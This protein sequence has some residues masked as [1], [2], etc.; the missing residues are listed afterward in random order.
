MAYLVTRGNFITA[1]GTYSKASTSF[2]TNKA[3][4]FKSS[5]GTKYAT[6]TYT[7]SNT[8]RCT[9]VGGAVFSITKSTGARTYIENADGSIEDIHSNNTGLKI[10]MASQILSSTMSMAANHPSAEAKNISYSGTP[11]VNPINGTKRLCLRTGT[12][13]YDVVKYGLTT[14]SS[15][16]QYCGLR[17]KIDGQTAYIGRSETA[18]STFSKG[19]NVSYTRTTSMR[20]N[21]TVSSSSYSTSYTTSSATNWYSYTTSSIT[22][23]I[24]ERS[25]IGA[26]MTSSYT[27]A[28][29]YSLPSKKGMYNFQQENTEDYEYNS[30]I[31]STSTTYYTMMQSGSYSTSY[32]TSSLNKTTYYTTSNPTRSAKDYFS[33]LSGWQFGASRNSVAKTRTSYIMTIKTVTSN[34]WLPPTYYSYT[35]SRT[36]STTSRTTFHGNYS[37][38]YTGTIANASSKHTGTRTTSYS[39]PTLTISSSSNLTTS[40]YTHTTISTRSVSS[41]SSSQTSG[42]YSTHGTRTSLQLHA[43]LSY[44]NPGYISFYTSSIHYHYTGSSNTTITSSASNSF[45]FTSVNGYTMSATRYSASSSS[46]KSFIANSSDKTACDIHTVS[47]GIRV[48]SGNY[49]SYTYES[50]S[51][52][53]SLTSATSGSTYR[54]YLSGTDNTIK[55]SSSTTS[56]TQFYT[57][58]INCSGSGKLLISSTGSH[59]Y[60]NYTFAS[61]T[62][63]YQSSINRKSSW[64]HEYTTSKSLSSRA[65][66]STYLYLNRTS[67]STSFTS[68]SYS[69][70]NIGTW[71]TRVTGYSTS[72]A[73]NIYGTYSRSSTTSGNANTSS[74]NY[75]ISTSSTVSS[76]TS[77]TTFASYYRTSYSYRTSLTYTRRASANSVA[78][79]MYVTATRYSTWSSSTRTSYYSTWSGY[80]RLSINSTSSF[81]TTSPYII[82]SSSNVLY[83]VNIGVYTT[84]AVLFEELHPAAST[85]N[86]YTCSASSSSTISGTNINGTTHG[87]IE[88]NRTT[89]L[90][91]NSTASTHI[92]YYTGSDAVIQPVNSLANWTK[93]ISTRLNWSYI[94]TAVSLACALGLL[95]SYSKATMS[96]SYLRYCTSST[97]MTNHYTTD[98][99]NL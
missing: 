31:L 56:S 94:N 97:M 85:G 39:T 73:S 91:S 4:Y 36:R 12:G 61:M 5:S 82:T 93:S 15:A 18:S 34:T 22:N 48:S 29:I 49:I 71:I 68:G 21:S 66:Y 40:R 72:S 2:Y 80:E 3:S 37:S 60:S 9:S 58:T 38:T 65:T 46:P 50:T 89:K 77:R 32:A 53:S 24:H 92:I 55:T 33:T 81:T 86:L 8:C 25:G 95:V 28:S 70:S 87:F 59:I 30:R 62:S 20:T 64:R 7:T 11:Y 98:N 41:G 69:A 51:L 19:K 75:T 52:S 6:Y 96:S 27:K 84:S 83:D 76:I 35:T 13:E 79:D 54:K 26:T 90:I 1:S 14:N 43:T 42:S 74:S 99:F 10:S 45:T 44:T 57:T 63:T 17:M 88:T 67:S 16:V 78:T 23:T 47:S